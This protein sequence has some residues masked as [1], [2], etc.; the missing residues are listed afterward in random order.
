MVG[1]ERTSDPATIEPVPGDGLAVIE[2]RVGDDRPGSIGGKL[3]IAAAERISDLNEVFGGS[4][5]WTKEPVCLLDNIEIEGKPKHIHDAGSSPI[6]SP[7]DRINVATEVVG[8]SPNPPAHSVGQEP[9]LSDLGVLFVWA[10]TESTKIGSL[11]EDNGGGE[12]HE[13]L[14]ERGELHRERLVGELF[15]VV[16]FGVV[17]L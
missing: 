6:E 8:G 10:E 1:T 16:C 7:L 3:S 11:A 13:G 4:I 9:K 17:E 12:D 2:L 5:S 15:G 14:N